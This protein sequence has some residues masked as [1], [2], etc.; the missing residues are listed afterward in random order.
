[1]IGAWFTVECPWVTTP[2]SA[3]RSPG[4]RRTVAPTAT[5]LAGT[6]SQLPSGCWTVAVSG[7]SS[8][9]PRIALR[10]RSSDLASITS[11]RANRNI[12]MAASG[13]SPMSIAPVTAIDISALMFRLRFLRAI[14]PFL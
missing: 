14:Q 7:A 4:R 11:A 13:H 3:M 1:M 9:R 12:T 5:C 8:I 10:A 2:S 6:A